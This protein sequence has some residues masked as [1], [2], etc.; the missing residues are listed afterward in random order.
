MSK[1]LT[2]SRRT[3]LRGLGV[4]VGLPWLEAMMPN[5]GLAAPASSAK[6]PR[7][8]A[9]FFVPNGKNMDLWRPG[10]TGELKELPATLK[11]LAEYRQQILMFSGLTLNGG[12]SLGDGPGDH[13]RCLASFLTGAHPHKTGGKDIRNGTSID[14]LIAQAIGNQTRL[15]SLELG[16]E[17][18][19]QAG[20]CDSGYSCVYSSAMSWRN[21]TSP[22]MKEINPR[23]VFDR[24][25]GG[26]DSVA[27]KKQVAERNED[28]KSILDF[29]LDDAKSLHRKLGSTD[30]QKLDEY[31]HAIRQIERQM[32]ETEKLEPGEVEAADYPRPE[33][34]PREFEQH[35]KVLLDMMVLAM[36]TD[37][38]RAL[39][40]MYGNAG[41]NRSYAN[42][43]VRQ[44]HHSLSH[45]GN[46]KGKLDSLAKINLLHVSLLKY[47]LDKLA[48][49]NEGDGTLLDNSMV[50]Y[51]SGIADPNRHRH[52]DLPILLAGGGGGTLQGGR[53]IKYPHDT[54]LTNLY[55][56]LAHRMGVRADK[57]ADSTGV[58]KDLG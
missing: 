29:V 53:H 46:D 11:P 55:L 35:V 48:N 27:Q 20:S 23:A 34:V 57:F 51:G 25:F 3:V 39:S 32:A 36:Q 30:R 19:R 1:N 54:P 47:F 6:P 9:F 58:L 44:G 2:V 24:L 4:A 8:A 33:G 38:T 13:A 12:R 31:L 42:I 26:G 16:I 22:I 40:F 49:I 41:S 56:S 21:E 7:R 15:P 50:F 52:E 18:S 45:H 43:G 5:R 17:P 10:S 37:S 14:Q 28:R